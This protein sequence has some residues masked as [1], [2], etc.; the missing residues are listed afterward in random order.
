MTPYIINYLKKSC[1]LM[2]IDNKCRQHVHCTFKVPNNAVCPDNTVLI[3]VRP[4]TCFAPRDP[5]LK[6]TNSS[7]NARSRRRTTCTGGLKE[8]LSARIF[9][10][11][12]S[13]QKKGHNYH[14]N[15]SRL[16]EIYRSDLVL[17]AHTGILSWKLSLIIILSIREEI[18]LLFRVIKSLD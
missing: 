6:K 5:S 14:S 4:S 1:L 16:A 18:I 17:R 10:S 8:S 7:P 2:R 15:V 11:G 3:P 12:L 9:D 13:H